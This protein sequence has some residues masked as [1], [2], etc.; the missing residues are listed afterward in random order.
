MRLDN[1]AS[2]AVPVGVNVHHRLVVTIKVQLLES[3]AFHPII[4]DI[5]FQTLF[6]HGE[7]FLVNYFVRL[8]T[9]CPLARAVEQGDV[10]LLGKNKAP[11]VHIGIPLA[12]YNLDFG[13]ANGPDQI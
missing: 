10:G 9:K 11:P 13:I 7:I 4:I 8:K 6:D 3:K 5:L 12:L 1:P 2:S